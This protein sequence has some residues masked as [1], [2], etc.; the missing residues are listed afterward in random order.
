[1][2]IECLRFPIPITVDP[3]DDENQVMT[4]A[5]NLYR[6]LSEVVPTGEYDYGHSADGSY[7]YSLLVNPNGTGVFRMTPTSLNSVRTEVIGHHRRLS[8]MRVPGGFSK[9]L[10]REGDY[11]S[12]VNSSDPAVKPS[13]VKEVIFFSEP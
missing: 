3:V 13:A 11:L 7:K 6:D 4:E 2:T 9:L 1:M 8:K 5:I 10:Q 12:M